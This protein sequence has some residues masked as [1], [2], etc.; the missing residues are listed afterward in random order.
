MTLLPRRTGRRIKRRTAT[1][2]LSSLSFA[3]VSPCAR[4]KLMSACRHGLL[5]R[6]LP[7]RS[8]DTSGLR[9]EG[10]GRKMCISFETYLEVE[11]EVGVKK[12]VKVGVICHAQ[13]DGLARCKVTEKRE[14]CKRITRFSFHFRV[15]SRSGEAKV[16]EKRK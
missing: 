15:F 2:F 7:I 8:S 5:F 9:R 14:K 16:T 13:D 6:L 10:A 11:V 12:G 1:T 3:C 4:P